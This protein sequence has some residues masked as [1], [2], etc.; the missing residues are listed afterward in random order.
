MPPKVISSPS[1]PSNPSFSAGSADL[2]VPPVSDDVRLLSPKQVAV[3]LGISSHCV[4]EMLRAEK[5]HGIRVGAGNG[6]WRVHPAEIQAYLERQAAE[7]AT[8]REQLA[9]QER[10]ADREIEAAELE[11]EARFAIRRA[12]EVKAEE[13]LKRQAGEGSAAS[14]GPLPAKRGR[15]RPKTL[16]ITH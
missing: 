13:D 4:C 11:R 2:A 10:L 16:G 15:G 14:P 3:R 7:Q 9:A 6:L 12:A 1:N 8:I 5:M